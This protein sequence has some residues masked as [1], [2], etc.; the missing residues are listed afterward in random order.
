MKFD[1][2]SWINVGT[3][4]F[5][6]GLSGYI[7]LAFSPSGQPYVGFRD[8]GNGCKATVMKFD[9]TNWVAVGTAGFTSGI[10]VNTSLAFNSSEDQPYLAFGDN[11]NGGKATVMKYDGASWVSVG[12]P[13]FTAGKAA[14]LSFAIGPIGQPA[15][16]FGDAANS[17]KATVMTFDGTSWEYLGTAGFSPIG[18]AYESIGFRPSSG[19]VYV[20]FVD[21]A[22]VNKVTVMK[23]DSLFVGLNEANFSGLSIYPNPA[24]GSITIDLTGFTEKIQDVGI[25]DIRGIQISSFMPSDK[26]ITLDIGNYPAGIYI[27]RVKTGSSSWFGK[28]CKN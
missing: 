6:A 7:S 19:D 26:K 21:S 8:C 25:I 28:F 16:A 12:T 10:V 2:T 13:G 23:N 24:F 4:G 20:A 3:P 22:S 14:D 27:V 1:G 18:A 11:Q 15:V 17:S 5:S 9:G